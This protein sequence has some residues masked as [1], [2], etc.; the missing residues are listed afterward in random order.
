MSIQYIYI[1]AQICCTVYVG[2]I[3]KKVF[4]LLLLKTYSV[5]E[6]LFNIKISCIFNHNVQKI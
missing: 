6:Q 4:E 3:Q 5:K 1:L 2:Q